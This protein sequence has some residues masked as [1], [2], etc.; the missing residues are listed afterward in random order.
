MSTRPLPPLHYGSHRIDD[1]D[2][3]AVVAALRSDRLTQGPLVTEFEQAIARRVGAPHVTAVSNGTAALHAA[4][5]ALGLGPGD[6]I[7]TSPIT[8]VATAN[9]ARMLGADVRFADVCAD[10]GNLDPDS[11][12]S[13]V[14]PRTRGIV[15]VHFG[16]LPAD[17]AR[18]RAIADRHGLWIV[19]DAAHALGAEYQG[20]AVGSCKYS[21][22][23][24]FSFHPV[25]HITTGEGGAVCTTDPALEQRMRQFREHGLVRIPAPDSGGHWG[26]R[27][28]ALGYNYRMCDVQCALGSSQLNKLTLWL[29]QRRRLAALYRTQLAALGLDWL[30]PSAAAQDSS[31]A[32]H[33]FSVLIDFERAGTSRAEVMGRLKE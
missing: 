32:Y 22:A 17:L 33:L 11:V 4:Y 29:D 26:Y 5:A 16:G 27:Q 23:T 24:T 9:A 30:M 3:A 18:L 8:F 12:A 15:P 19:E 28:D 7:I 13:L 21:Q 31:H 1:A 14:G 20:H 25:K 6:E 2:V 10:S